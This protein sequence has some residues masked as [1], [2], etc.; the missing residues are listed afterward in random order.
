MIIERNVLR[1]NVMVP[2]F[3][4]IDQM[5]QEN[6]GDYLYHCTDIVYPRLVRDFW[7]FGDHLG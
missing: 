7:I 3:D 4:F 1:A 5:I 2:P 6:H